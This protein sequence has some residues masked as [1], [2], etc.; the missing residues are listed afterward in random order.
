MQSLQLNYID[1]STNLFQE[2]I[3][4]TKAKVYVFDNNQNK[5]QAKKYYQQPFLAQSS[6]FLTIS[7]LKEKVFTSD[8]LVL[9]EEKLT[10]IFYELLTKKDKEKL[11][12]NTYYDIIDL[13]A[14]YF[15]FYQE[16]NEYNIDMIDNLAGWQLE[17]YQLFEELR[18]RYIA[19]LEKLAYTDRTLV[20][21][22]DNFNP[23]FLADY[24]EL[25]FVNLLE[26]TPKERELISRLAEEGKEVS[27][28]NQIA[29]EDYNEE[30]LKLTDMILP[31]SLEQKVELYQSSEEFLQLVNALAKL[32]QSEEDYLILD[33]NFAN[34]NYHNL[35]SAQKVKV[36]Q[37]SSFT[38]SNLYRFLDALHSLLKTADLSKGRLK[39]SMEALLAAS[40]LKVFR[41]YYDLTEL[42]LK[43]LVDLAQADYVYFDESLCLEGLEQFKVIIDEIK[44]I[45]KLSTLGE[46]ISFLEGLDKDKLVEDKYKNTISQYFGALAELNSIEEMNLVSSWNKYFKNSSE[47]LFRLILNYLRFKK[48]KSLDN[49][50]ESRVEIKDLLIS[51]FA[52]HNRIIMLNI[53]EGVIPTLSSSNFLLTEEQRSKLGLRTVEE[54]RL[55]EKYLFFRHIFS[56]Q[57]VIIYA[58]ENQDKNIDSSSFLE[59]L[60]LK[61][62][63]PLQSV[64]LNEKHYPTII[65]SIFASSNNSLKDRLD[66]THRQQDSLKLE[67]ADFEGQLS[68]SYY[69]ATTLSSCHYCF[70]LEHIAKLSE[71]RVEFEKKISPK[72][73][74]IIVHEVFETIINNYGNQ[75]MINNGS[76]DEGIITATLKLKLQAYELKLPNYYQKYYHKVLFKLIAGSI[77]GFFEKLKRKVPN[78]RQIDSEWSLDREERRVFLDHQKAKVY[79]NGRLDLIL[80][81]ENN[82]KYI[83]DYKTGSS[84][85]EQLD[86]Y[87][88]LYNPD[89]ESDEI[90]QKSIYN[91]MKESF[92]DG[93][94]N[95]E[96]EFAQKLQALLQDFLDSK[97]YSNQYKYYCNNCSYSEICKV[98]LK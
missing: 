36:D 90:I 33:G 89:F 52:N 50:E 83:I 13:S 58:I 16:L 76:L 59:E 28:Y 80:E 56:S 5:I 74:G 97:E 91:V 14:E 11:K 37:D 48:I 44:M 18:A 75:I 23:I 60:R 85:Q 84:S 61:Y 17:K 2:V 94:V 86:F 45:S 51:S 87:S 30:Q 8:K 3:D 21:D 10:L 29:K 71:E 20:Y 81:D 92:E 38:N 82:Q 24:Q 39:L 6:L 26:S 12:V 41:A 93:K 35:L 25:V 43:N 34:S 66:I 55:K 49:N 15:N 79:L 65:D 7:E 63:L 53:N 1:Y 70:F 73:I 72:V 96:E 9:K 32:N 42:D 95:S 40:Y 27:I 69:K 88:L 19:K 62:N 54:I 57:D 77:K 46:Y 22:F 47:G 68:L 4:N 31:D 98:V 78:I 67:A 64:E